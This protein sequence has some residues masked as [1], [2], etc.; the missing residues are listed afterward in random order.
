METPY[1]PN[2]NLAKRFEAIFQEQDDDDASGYL[3]DFCESNYDEIV[4]ALR[5]WE[6]SKILERPN[7][8]AE[9]YQNENAIHTEIEALLK[10]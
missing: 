1:I 7:D 5:L 3:F 9:P 2:N 10:D 4:R 8:K 6:A